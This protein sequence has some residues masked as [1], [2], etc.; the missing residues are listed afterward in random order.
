MMIAL[1]SFHAIGM[2]DIA[3]D[4]KGPAIGAALRQARIEHL[5]VQNL[6]KKY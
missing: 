5:H 3:P 1:N 2:T 4:L 6:H